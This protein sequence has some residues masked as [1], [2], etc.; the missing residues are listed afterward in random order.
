MFSSEILLANTSSGFY[1]GVSTKSLKFTQHST[2]SDNERLT[3]TMGTVDSATDFSINFWVKRS[4]LLNSRN[5]S[6]PMTILTFRDGTSG[7]ALNEVQFG[8]HGTWGDG[9]SLCVTHTNSGARIL[10]TTNLLRDTTAWYNIHIRGDLDNGT[11]SEKLKIYI[12]NVEASYATDNRSSY[13]EMTGFKA[14]AW[15]IGDYY[16]YGYSPACLLALFT[17]T[18]GH[19]YLPTDFCEVKEGALIPKNPSVTYGNGG[20]RLAFA[21]GTGVGT[22]SSTTVGADTS[23]QNNHWTTTNIAAANVFPDNPEDNYPT[24]NPLH[25]GTDTITFTEGNLNSSFTSD[26]DDTHHGCTF[27]LPKEGKW[28]WEQT[29]TGAA[30]DGSQAPYCGIYDDDTL[31]L[32]ISDNFINSGGDFITY[33]THNNSIKIATSSTDYTGSIGNQTGAVVG[34]AVDMDNGHLWVHVN[35]TYINGTPTFSDGTNKV[36]SPNTDSTYIPFWSGN[37]GGAMTWSANFG[38]SSFTGTKPS[39]Y[40]LLTSAN[41]P[42]PTLG[43]N[44]DEQPDDFFETLIFTG[45]SS[46]TRTI[47]GLNLQPDLL[48]SKARNQGFSHRLYDSTRGN[49]KGVFSNST[50]IESTHD[51]FNGF[52][53]DGYNT[54]TDGSAGDLLNYNTGTYINYFW[55]ANAGTTTTNDASSTGVGSIDSVYQANTTS[56]FSIVTYTGTGSSNGTIAHGLGAIPKLMFIKGLESGGSGP[57]NWICYHAQNTS[58]PE[59]DYLY[60][61]TTAATDDSDTIFNDTAPTSTVFSVGSHVTVNESGVDYVAYLWAEVE[62][63]SKFGKFTASGSADGAYVHCGFQPSLVIIKQSS[64]TGDW[65][66][67]DTTR[68]T[69]NHVNGLPVVRANTS[70]AEEH[71]SGNQGQ[72]DILSNGF[73][74]RSNHSSFN[75]SGA[76]VI[77]MAWAK[78]PEKYSLAF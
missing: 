76:T 27:A 11:A 63:F 66:M 14:G 21:S 8:E 61:S 52:T 5:T 22:A 17:Y 65:N 40:S 33:Y 18:D 39:G 51:V 4:D 53:S 25:K 50:A 55:K 67:I 41:L 64:A 73:K 6:Y 48:W 7:T 19:K 32:G 57:H 1:N 42:E 24:M 31:A 37:G 28:Y 59:T 78:M 20:F 38:Q 34:F 49:D 47:S 13:S 29:F 2:G 3:R 60:L 46:A 62:N 54:T 69:H 74:L 77:Y 15:T 44:S 45:N 68:Q 23:G 16:N 35:G 72:I 75:T 9:D 10:G 30:T 70:S 26:T 71:A 56:D 36:A 58:A 12:N 43:P